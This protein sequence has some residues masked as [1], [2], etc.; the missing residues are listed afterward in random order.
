M[1][2]TGGDASTI[3]LQVWSQ[4]GF[5]SPNGMVIYAGE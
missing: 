3:S 1:V 4:I 2:N 5:H